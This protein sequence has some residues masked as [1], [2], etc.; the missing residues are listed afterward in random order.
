MYFYKFE[1]LRLL[2]GEKRSGFD[3]SVS[4]QALRTLRT[5]PLGAQAQSVVLDDARQRIRHAGLAKPLLVDT[6][7]LHYVQ[8]SWCPRWF[9]IGREFGSSLGADPSELQ[10]ILEAH[11]QDG[12]PEELVF[13]PHNVDTPGMA[14]SLMLLAQTWA[15]W[16][17]SVLHKPDA[18]R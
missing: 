3:F 10:R 15:E 12:G 5:V 6:A 14:L 7:A 18:F 16:A 11:P 2:P 13:T 9:E 4:A 8:G 17:Q 1:G